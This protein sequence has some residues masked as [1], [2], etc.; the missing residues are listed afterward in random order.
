MRALAV[1]RVDADGLSSPPAIALVR[2][3]ERFPSFRRVLARLPQLA[4][5]GGGYGDFLAWRDQRGLPPTSDEDLRDEYENLCE[6]TGREPEAPRPLAEV[7]PF[8]TLPLGPFASPCLPKLAE[9]SGTGRA[10][11]AVE[12][13]KAFLAW[14]Q[15]HALI[16]D[17]SSEDMSKFYA[18]FCAEN[19]HTPIAENV[20]RGELAKLHTLGARRVQVD[21]RVKGEGRKRPVVWKI[22]LAPSAKRRAS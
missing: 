22:E 15:D 19:S 3:V 5:I 14:L 20:L 16:G 6:L 21:H 13:A 10:I 1:K 7:V 11:S 8:P 4:P 2:D 18:R 9:V 12:A 17:W